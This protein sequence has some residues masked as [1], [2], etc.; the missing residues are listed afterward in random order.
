MNSDAVKALKDLLR[1]QIQRP[2]RQNSACDVEHEWADEML[3]KALDDVELGD[4]WQKSRKH[5]WYS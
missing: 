3:V 2:C 4:L 5:R 1:V